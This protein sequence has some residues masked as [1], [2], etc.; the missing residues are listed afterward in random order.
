[1]NSRLSRFRV[2]LALLLGLVGLFACT[3]GGRI[4]SGSV[5]QQ[6]WD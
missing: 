1:M 4:G 5:P 2:L 6:D 3:I